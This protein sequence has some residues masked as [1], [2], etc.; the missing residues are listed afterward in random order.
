M[1]RTSQQWHA[2]CGASTAVAPRVDA[3]AAAPLSAGP[4][5]S[6]HS[7]SRPAEVVK[8]AM[9]SP[10]QRRSFGLCPGQAMPLYLDCP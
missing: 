2:N 10:A 1:A 5:E 6:R 9:T 4:K 8:A 3:C 7:T